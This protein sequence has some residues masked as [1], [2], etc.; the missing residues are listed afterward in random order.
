MPQSASKKTILLVEDEAVIAMDEVM[1]LKDHGFDV[2]SVRSGEKAI[3]TVDSHSVDMILMDIDLGCGMDGTE[4]AE[5]ILKEH[6]L[7][8][9]FLSSHTEPGIVD[10]TEKITSYGYIVK[11]S[12]ETV[13]IASIRMAFRLFEANRERKEKNL[14][15]ETLFNNAPDL[16]GRLDRN[17]KHLYVN[18]SLC[19][20]MGIPFDEYVGKNIDELGAPEDLSRKWN[21]AVNLVFET[22]EENEVEF[23]VGKGDG[24]QVIESKIVPEIIEHGTVKTVVV[25]SRDITERKRNED[26]L[27]QQEQYMQRVFNGIGMA[28]FVVEVEGERFLLS[29]LNQL[30]KKSIIEQFGFEDFT[31]KYLDELYSILPSQIV[32]AA[33]NNYIR[34]V[35]SG[36]EI[37]YEEPGPVVDGIQTFFFTRLS[38]VKDTH[39]KVS[40]IIGSTMDI[41]SRVQS[42]QELKLSEER[43][44][45]ISNI[46][47]DYAYCHRLKGDGS[48]EPVWHIGSFDHITGYTPEELYRLGGWRSL[49]HTEDI[50]RTRE[51]VETLL[52]GKETSVTARIITKTGEH[53]WIRD[54]GRP[55]IEEESGKVIGTYGAA[56]D[57]TNQHEIEEAL[58]ASKERLRKIFETENVAIA[59]S[60]AE[61]GVYLEANPGF[62][63]VTGY[64]YDEIIGRSSQELDFM[65]DE[66]RRKLADGIKQYGC[67]K[68]RELTFPTKSGERK[69]VLFCINSIIIDNTECFLAVMTDITKQKDV[70][71]TLRNQENKYRQMF[72][73]HSAIIL[74]I[75]P[76]AGGQIIDVN[77]SAVDFYGYTRKEFLT[78]KITDINL[79]PDA[80][81]KEHME[82]A[83][84]RKQEI[85][86]FRHKL[87]DGTVKDVEVHSSPI[88][89]NEKWILRSIIR[90]I[91]DRNNILREKEIL[92]QE[93]NHRVK[94]NL[95]MIS[96]LISLK[97]H[98]L[99][100]LADLSDLIHQVDAIRIIHEKLYQ[101]D[102]ISV[103][104]LKEYLNDLFTTIFSFSPKEVTVTSSVEIET[105]KTR[106]AIP[107]GLI[108]NEVATNAIKHGY[109]GVEK[110]AFT[111]SFKKADNQYILTLSNTGN[112]FPENVDMENPETLG[113]R[114]I[115]ALVEQ[116]DGTLHLV[117]KPR[118]VYTIQFPA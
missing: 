19:A 96:S 49:I 85:F 27:R 59:L 1:T 63:K 5:I 56:V 89:I 35:E 79:L 104:N 7:P 2:I 3:E 39:G 14:Q 38:P 102:T 117:R 82:R 44:R 108:I 101:S 6:D 43:C 87:A 112:P 86:E 58:R 20:F 80:E 69:T 47:V 100:S 71:K 29:K 110:P 106:T 51:Y 24:V 52:S 10:K 83:K 88:F 103:I 45:M 40:R 68:D 61:D 105:I 34:C 18:Q 81:V 70:E 50:P 37:Q 23:T 73:Q 60:R 46:S 66:Y 64:N 111:I 107:L 65:T 15:L 113:L 94:N 78:K 31:G 75:N 114:L 95:L 22:A 17:K 90:D 99:G 30:Y 33:A 16:I 67:L 57:V 54:K 13:L 41:T 76:D 84:L 93:L 91:T 92:M 36:E 55:W 12:G 115:S 116:L 8:I 9:V 21:G 62:L 74:L 42:E 25:I 72:M 118:P 4:A 26:L 109:A 11:N 77:K 48:L 32:D 53:R 97:N 28:V 98:S